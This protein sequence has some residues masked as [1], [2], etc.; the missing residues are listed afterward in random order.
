METKEKKELHESIKNKVLAEWEKGNVCFN[1]IE[2]ICI[3]PLE[4]FTQQPLEGM[5]YDMNRDEATILTLINDKKWINDYCLTRLLKHYY[6]RCEEL[7]KKIAE[8]G[9]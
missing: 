3:Q 4:W 9:K 8:L 7:E 5:L 1:T 2:G 6:N